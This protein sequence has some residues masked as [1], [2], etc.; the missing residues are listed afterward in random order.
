MQ[1][2]LTRVLLAASQELAAL[3][4]FFCYFFRLL[5]CCSVM[6]PVRA[7]LAVVVGAEALQWLLTATF[8]SMFARASVSVGAAGQTAAER[9]DPRRR[10][11][12]APL[13]VPARDLRLS[14]LLYRALDCAVLPAGR[15]RARGRDRSGGAHAPLCERRP[16]GE[17]P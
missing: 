8:V 16:H 3:A 1:S 12:R 14:P 11:C 9:L 7:P 4:W 17:Q 6:R 2:F 5:C 10:T 15:D 13:A